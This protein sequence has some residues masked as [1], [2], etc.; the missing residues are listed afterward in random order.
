MLFFVFFMKFMI[1]K[2]TMDIANYNN[3]ESI[4]LFQVQVMSFIELKKQ[5]SLS[6]LFV[7]FHC[8]LKD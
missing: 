7:L 1:P 3:K 8:R 6:L 5:K 2:F 4:Q